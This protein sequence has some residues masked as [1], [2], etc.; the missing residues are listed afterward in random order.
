[1]RM[2]Q[3]GIAQA[4]PAIEAQAVLVLGNL[5]RFGRSV[6]CAGRVRCIGQANTI[7][8]ADSPANKANIEIDTEA[9]K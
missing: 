6:V 3:I 5:E 9:I 2:G 8:P 1:M 7:R 4:K